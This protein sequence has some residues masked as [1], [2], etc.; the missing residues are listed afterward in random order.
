M[1]P[2][3]PRQPCSCH[4]DTHVCATRAV[5][6]MCPAGRVRSSAPVMPPAR[7]CL[8]CTRQHTRRSTAAATRPRMRTV[9][10]TAPLSK[11]P[12]TQPWLEPQGLPA[13]PNL[14]QL[15]R[16]FNAPAPLS[17][18]G[19]SACGYQGHSQHNVAG[20]SDSSSGE[21]RAACCLHCTGIA[22]SNRTRTMQLSTSSA[23]AHG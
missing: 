13:A 16:Q 19:R 3:T 8:G 5:M 9:R 14:L 17:F 2:N 20:S 7:G 6:G 15:V 10:H 23:S 21:Q 12:D 1:Q 4:N 22:C 18:A 11:A